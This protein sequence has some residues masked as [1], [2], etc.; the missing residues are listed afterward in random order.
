MLLG[1]FVAPTGTAA[2]ELVADDVALRGFTIKN[3]MIPVKTYRLGYKR[4]FTI[5]VGGLAGAVTEANRA[6][7]AAEYLAKTKTNAGVETTYLLAE[8]PPLDGTLLA[9]GTEA[10]T[11][12]DRRGTLWSVLRY[13]YVAR[14]FAAPYK[15]RLGQVI[16]LYHP[17]FGFAAG[18]LATLIGYTWYPT[19]KRATLELFA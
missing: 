13:I 1:Q 9:D 15:L 12:C 18:K 4:N 11:E 16:K 5:Q 19:R 10:Q 3:R 2:L 17:R 6:A 8:N 7:Y 14:C